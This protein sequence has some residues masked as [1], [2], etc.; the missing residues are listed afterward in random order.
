MP[1]AFVN[2][3]CKM[4]LMPPRKIEKSD[5]TR[6]AIE[7]AGRRLFAEQ[8]YE[9]TT[10]REIAREAGIDASLVIRYFGSKDGLFATV[11]E[12]DLHLPNLA[13][14]DPVKIGE[15]LVSHFMD[16]WEG[17]S[18]MPVLLRSAA[19]NEAAADRLKQMFARQVGPA[20]ASAGSPEL[21][22]R[23]AGL[24]AS[25]LLGL[26]M[27]RYILRL[28]PVVA[29]ERDFVVREVGATIQRYITLGNA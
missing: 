6:A 14:V 23:R 8:G 28:P 27:T 25:Q 16:V 4:D 19:S 1:L 17:P 5:R 10:V 7:Q 24:I 9:R 11:A 15:V 3:R 18:G 13:E 21:A 20:V 26:A 12:P 2:D 29:M 22:S